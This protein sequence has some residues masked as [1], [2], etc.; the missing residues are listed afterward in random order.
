MPEFVT[1]IIDQHGDHPFGVYK[2][3]CGFTLSIAVTLCDDAPVGERCP[4]CVRRGGAD[5][6]RAMVELVERID[7]DGGLTNELVDRLRV[8]ARQARQL[9]L[10]DL[11]D[12]WASVDD[13]RP[14][15]NP[16]PARTKGR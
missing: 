14:Q 12:Q 7:A 3:A 9:Q 11:V 1:H 6:L 5:V 8:L 2:A 13:A 10:S 15:C 16:T 4:Q